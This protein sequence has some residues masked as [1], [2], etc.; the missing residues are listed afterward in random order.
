MSPMHW[1]P[2]ESEE[3]AFQW[4]IIVLVGAVIVIALVLLFRAVS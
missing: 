2:I 1:N 4:L 3:A